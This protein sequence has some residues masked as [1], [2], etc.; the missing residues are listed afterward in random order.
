MPILT[1]ISGLQWKRVSDTRMQSECG[2]YVVD[3]SPSYD[4]YPAM[5]YQ[6]TATHASSAASEPSAEDVFCAS[7]RSFEAAADACEQDLLQQQPKG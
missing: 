7:F 5:E 3:R 4:N 2:R 1:R 6:Y